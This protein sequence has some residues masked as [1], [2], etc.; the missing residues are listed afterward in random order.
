MK[1]GLAVVSAVLILGSAACDRHGA[2]QPGARTSTEAGNTGRMQANDAPG[3]RDPTG[4]AQVDGSPATASTDAVQPEASSPKTGPAANA[5]PSF[6]QV[7]PG[8]VMAAAPTVADGAD[9]PGGMV[10]FTT[11][12]D[13]DAVIGFYKSHAEA[14]GLASVMSMNQG[15]SRGYGALKQDSG[16]RLQ[17][18]ATALEGAKTSV[19]LTWSLGE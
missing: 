10:S 18:V 15:E 14:A 19:L 16:A 4:S 13:P 6:A 11:P 5:T 7:Y 12:A 1:L 3:G 8:A 17:V 9:G 2:T